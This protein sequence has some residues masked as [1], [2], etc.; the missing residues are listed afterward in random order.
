MSGESSHVELNPDVKNFNLTHTSTH[1]VYD[2]RAQNKTH[3][4]KNRNTE[5]KHN[6]KESSG[7]EKEHIKNQEN[8]ISP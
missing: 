6:N 2:T 8:L 5:N 1:P 4:T 7:G 3:H